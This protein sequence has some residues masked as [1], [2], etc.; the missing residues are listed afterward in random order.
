[1]GSDIFL[2]NKEIAETQLPDGSR[3]C[4]HE[5]IGAARDTIRKLRAAVDKYGMHIAMTHDAEWIKGQEDDV[6]MSLLHPFFD[7]ECLR[8]IRAHQQP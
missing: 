4:L 2:G 1:M 7:A 3:F 8:N 6:L 5:D